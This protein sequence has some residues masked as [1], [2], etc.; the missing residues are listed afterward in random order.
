[1]I[2]AQIRA[3][4]EVTPIQRENTDEVAFATIHIPVFPSRSAQLE[5]VIQERGVAVDHSP[6]TAGF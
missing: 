6:L 4:K 3:R 1:M 5:E 2:F